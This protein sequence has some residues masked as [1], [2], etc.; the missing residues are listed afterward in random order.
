MSDELAERLLSRLLERAAHQLEEG[1]LT[2]AKPRELIEA[3]RLLREAGSGSRVATE[4]PAE[5]LERLR[6]MLDNDRRSSD[7]R[8]EE[9]CPTNPP[10]SGDACGD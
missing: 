3:V 2:V 9:S 7:D 8:A 6:R 5:L 10:I 4:I 1:E